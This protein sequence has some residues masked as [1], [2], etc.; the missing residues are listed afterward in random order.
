MDLTLIQQ[1]F[2]GQAARAISWTLIHS[3]WEG[4]FFALAA[5]ITLLGTGRSHPSVRY[6]MLSIQFL[7]FLFII[8]GTF[9][10]EWNHEDP[11][12]NFHSIITGNDNAPAVPNNAVVQPALQYNLL[13]SVADFLSNHTSTLLAVWFMIFLLKSIKVISSLAWLQRLRLYKS[14]EPD[15][16]WKTKIAELGIRLGI[17]KVVRLMESELIR[18]PAVFGHLKPV[19]FI[20]LGILANMPSQQVEAV[21]LHELAHIRRSDYLFNLVQNIAET[22]FFFNPALLWLSSLVRQ[23][24]EHCCDDIAIAETG[25][26]KQFIET[27]IRFREIYFDHRLTYVPAFPGTRNSFLNRI[28]RIAMKKNNSLHPAENIFLAI[29]LVVIGALVMAF[30]RPNQPNQSKPAFTNTLAIDVTPVPAIAAIAAPI[31]T[32]P[33]S[34]KLRGSGAGYG[35]GNGKGNGA[36]QGE[37]EETNNSYSVIYSDVDNSTGRETVVFKSEGNEYKLVKLN[38]EISYLVV[39]DEKIPKDKLGEYS[40]VLK[41]I[42][43]QLERMRKEQLVR[44][45]EQARRNEEQKVRNREQEQRNAEQEIRNKEQERRNAEQVGRN[46]EHLER[47]KEQAVRN[48]EQER[49][50]AEQ[51]IRNKEQEQRNAEQVVRNKEQEQR[52]AE[53][54]IRN[55]E[56]EV[57]NAEMKKLTEDLITD[58]IIKDKRDLRSMSIDEDEL[59]VNGVK[60]PADVFKKYKSKYP[61]L[62]GSHFTYRYD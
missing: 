45:E 15:L 38:G 37:G 3:V 51:V 46:Q 1:L 2:S 24:R 41:K 57:R 25:D 39:N 14:Y 30:C 61:K 44:D 23:E 5:G 8:A 18:V 58:G 22:V 42:N 54:A 31:D 47:D 28:K 59:I 50:N 33:K 62:L 20:P 9:A 52:N 16:Y 27:L 34:K 6:R 53:Q 48:K 13:D 35:Q 43:S 60:Q 11:V 55:K 26:R 4:L 40:E 32:V 36:G 49:R 10:W 29:S 21:L 12:N 7:F 19:I 56:Q 17:K